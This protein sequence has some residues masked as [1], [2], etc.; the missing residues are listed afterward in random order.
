[1]SLFAQQFSLPADGKWY[2]VAKVGGLHSEFEYTYKHTTAHTPSLVSGTGKMILGTRRMFDKY[3]WIQFINSQN[4]SIQE[5]HSMGY[6]NLSIPINMA[7][8]ATAVCTI[9]Y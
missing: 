2:L 4:F 9:N 7:F 6:A 5:H 8:I 1:M 3:G